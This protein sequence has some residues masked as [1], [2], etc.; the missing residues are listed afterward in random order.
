MKSSI[1]WLIVIIERSSHPDAP[2][3]GKHPCCD[4][5]DLPVSEARPLGL[6]LVDRHLRGPRKL[7]AR[8]SLPRQRPDLVRSQWK[9]SL[10]VVSPEAAAAEHLQ[11]E[12]EQTKALEG[13]ASDEDYGRVVRLRDVPGV[14]EL[15]RQSH[16]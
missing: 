9:Y 7:P 2:S 5:H 8:S 13:D 11:M 12:V 14:G 10:E 1:P 3:H 6:D 4:S 16:W 15:D